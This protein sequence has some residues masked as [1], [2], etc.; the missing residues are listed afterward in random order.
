MVYVVRFAYPPGPPPPPPPKPPPPPLPPE[1]RNT[2]YTYTG[3][4]TI[5]PSVVFD[6]GRF[7]YFKW[8]DAIAS[9]AVFLMGTDGAESIVNYASRDGYIV[10]EQLAPRFVLRSGK[11]M[12]IL[13]NDGWQE[14]ALGPLAPRPRDSKALRDAETAGVAR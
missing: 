6:D 10:V 2:A 5:L 13:V 3:D 12:T 4:R 11:A 9:P 1:R 8:P 7:T 14:P